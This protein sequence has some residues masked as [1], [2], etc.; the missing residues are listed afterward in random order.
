MNIEGPSLLSGRT[1]NVSIMK[2]NV[3]II[4]L[5]VMAAGIASAQ[6]TKS[7]YDYKLTDINGKTY[8]MSELKGKKA[9]I[10][11]TASHCSLT[12]QV[13]EMEKL[14]KD[15]R[16]NLVIIAVP[17]NDFGNQEPGSNEEIKSFVKENDLTFPVMEKTSVTGDN[18][19]PLYQW[20]TQKDLNGSMDTKVNWNY[21][22]YMIDENGKLV[23]V[24][25]SKESLDSD[26]V[27]AWL[28]EK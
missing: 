19:N 3:F 20:L 6:T 27:K 13:K 21:Q 18:E 8:D 25:E 26:K 24:V 12:P 11:N 4:L 28:E 9:L 22:K 23:G 7:I 17:S 1:L 15:F 2:K 5:S 14:Y 10:V 16:D